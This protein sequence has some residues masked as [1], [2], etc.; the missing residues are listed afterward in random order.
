[1][2]IPCVRTDAMVAFD[3]P[4]CH[5]FKADDQWYLNIPGCGLAGL[6]NHEVREHDDGTISVYPSILT[7]G[8]HDGREV[9]RHGFLTRGAW[10]GCDDDVDPTV[11]ADILRRHQP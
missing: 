8:H 10:Y 9:R 3:D 1:M 4:E 7:T 5:Y 11:A 6:R 2:P